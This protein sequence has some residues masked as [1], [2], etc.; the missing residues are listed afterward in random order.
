MLI[1]SCACFFH[2]S[3]YVLFSHFRYLLF[4]WPL[5]S[6]FI[7]VSVNMFFLCIVA[8]L[9]WYQIT[10]RDDP[11]V[12]QSAQ[13]TKIPHEEKQKRVRALLERERQKEREGIVGFCYHGYL[14]LCCPRNRSN[15]AMNVILHQA[16][17]SYKVNYIYKC[18]GQG[19]T[20]IW[21]HS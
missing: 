3:C 14:V 6:S 17:I 16:Y 21:G 19:R 15:T 9:S 5:L 13:P 18:I 11:S 4:H 1:C 10:F 2:A 8:M 7:G 12:D 20:M